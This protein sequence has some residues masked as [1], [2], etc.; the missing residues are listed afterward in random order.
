MKNS[1]DTFWNRTSELPICCA[2]PY[3]LCYR[4]PRVDSQYRRKFLS[5]LQY[6]GSSVGITNGHVLEVRGS[7][8]DVGQT[9]RTR[10]DW[11]WGPT[12]LLYKGYRPFPGGKERPERQADPSSL[13][14]QWSRNIR[15]IPLLPVWAVRPVQSPVPLQGCTLPLPISLL[16]PMGRTSCTEPQCLYSTAIPLLPSVPVQ[17]SYNST[18]SMGRMDC[19]EPQCL[20]S[21]ATP[22]HPSVPVQYS[23]TSTPPM[24]RTACT[25]P[26]C[27]YSRAIPLLPLWII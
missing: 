18:P 4:C 3:P 15:A 25:E 5:P 23:Y 11:L 26:Q 16:R 8:P 7:N 20:Y 12:I 21:T 9:F 24:G 17:Y 2:A 22:L 10:P 6:R 19:T 1:N 14:V 27:L 13:L